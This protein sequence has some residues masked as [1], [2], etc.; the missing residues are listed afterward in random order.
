MDPTAFTL[1]CKIKALG[2]EAQSLRVRRRQA[3]MNIKAVPN[4]VTVQCI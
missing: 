4:E 3:F 2:F 1:S